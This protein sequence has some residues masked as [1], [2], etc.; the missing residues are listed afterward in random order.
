[1]QMFLFRLDNIVSLITQK[2][3]VYPIITQGIHYVKF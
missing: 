3:S 2:N 1:V